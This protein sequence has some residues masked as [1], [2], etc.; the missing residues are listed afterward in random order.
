MAF[1]KQTIFDAITIRATGHLE[2]RMAVIVLEDAEEVARKFHRRIITP[3]DNIS[4]E[5]AK[6]Q[7]IA[8]LI[9]TP[10]MIQAAQAVKNGQI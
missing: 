5:P 2:V 4:T 7:Q 1:S 8:N 10:A 3:G 9:W 6:I